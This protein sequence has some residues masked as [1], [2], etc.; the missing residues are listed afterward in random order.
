MHRWV[1]GECR[2]L[3]DSDAP[4]VDPVLQ[5]AAAALRERPVLFK[6]CAEEVATA[7]HNALFQ[8]CE[9]SCSILYVV[10][11]ILCATAEDMHRACQQL[12]FQRLS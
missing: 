1:Q 12:L 11:Y 4:E 3:G 6:Y 5:R 8:R 2:R 9:G 10:Q 7:R